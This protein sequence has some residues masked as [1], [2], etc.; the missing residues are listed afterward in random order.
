M[1]FNIGIDTSDV[2]PV[3]NRVIVELGERVLDDPRAALVDAFMEGMRF[4]NAELIAQLIEQGVPITTDVRVETL[5]E[6][7]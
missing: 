3:A 2:L 4:A 5:G 1:T 6:G 7:T